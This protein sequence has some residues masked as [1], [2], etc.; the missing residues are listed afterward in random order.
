MSWCVPPNTTR[1]ALFKEPLLVPIIVTTGGGSS[2]EKEPHGE[3]KKKEMKQLLEG[4]LKKEVAKR[5]K[6]EKKTP[7]MV[8]VSSGAS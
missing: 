1:R 8:M 6:L 2:F 5:V 7:A 3:K 4:T